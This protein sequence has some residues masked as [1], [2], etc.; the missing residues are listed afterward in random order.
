[1][2]G[3]IY[4]TDD[5]TE[6][7]DVP[8]ILKALKKAG[9]TNLTAH[10]HTDIRRVNLIKK[11]FHEP[12]DIYMAGL[13]DELDLYEIQIGFQLTKSKLLKFNE[14]LDKHETLESDMVEW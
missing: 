7:K 5:G 3:H 9:A 14:I 4:F 2:K 11:G 10:L 13:N 6:P 8:P 1:M 12:N